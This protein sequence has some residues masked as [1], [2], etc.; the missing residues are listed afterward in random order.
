MRKRE[1]RKAILAARDRLSEEE[2]ARLSRRIQEA[3]FRE[4]AFQR[5]GMVLFFHTIRS[6]VDTRPMI[7]A[8]LEAGKRVALP[9]VA[10]GNRLEVREIRR[11][12]RLAPGPMGILEPGKDCPLVPDGEIE[13]VI[14][15]A[16]AWDKEGYRTGYG[17]GYYDRLL[18][19][20]KRARKIGIGF[21]VQ[22]VER[23]PREGHDL[24]VDLLITEA[25]RREFGGKG[26]R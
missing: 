7:A 12:Q 10:P 13:V 16:V 2:I 5:A 8:A 9:R 14:V 24:P 19:R 4:E 3:L 6:E 15:P 17:G 20:L 25:G 26:G 18:A 22:V 23:A 1:L 11:G 21:E